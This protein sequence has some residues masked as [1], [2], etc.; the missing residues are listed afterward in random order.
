MKD[1]QLIVY[2]AADMDKAKRFFRELIG[3]DPYADSPYYVGYKSGNTEIG[4]VPGADEPIAYW[5][6]DDIAERVKALV[7]AGGT[8]VQDINDV[9]NGLLVAAIKEPNGAVIGLRQ[10]PKG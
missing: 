2:P 1:V 8:V 10:F 7:A 6:V 5:N 4:L 9:A 3:S